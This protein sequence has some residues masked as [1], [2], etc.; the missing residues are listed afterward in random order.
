MRT[1][2]RAR[3]DSPR[4]RAERHEK[5]YQT[6]I[7]AAYQNDPIGWDQDD[8]LARADRL[9]AFLRTT[10]GQAMLARMSEL[11]VQFRFE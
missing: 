9:R 2:R 10:T 7:A 5:A 4:A 11:G 6:I 8:L 1:I 3:D